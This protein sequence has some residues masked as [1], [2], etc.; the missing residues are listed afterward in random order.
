[1]VRNIFDLIALKMAYEMPANP[2]V[3]ELLTFPV[4]LLN[5]ILTK[6]KQSGSS[7]LPDFLGIER[8]RDTNQ[9]NVFWISSTAQTRFPNPCFDDFNVFRDHF[10]TFKEINIPQD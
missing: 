9:E 2:I 4:Q 3:R 1:M 7:C 10:T 6:I 8:F 5:V